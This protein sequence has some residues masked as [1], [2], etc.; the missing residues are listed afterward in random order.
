MTDKT[1]ADKIYMEP[2]TLDYVAK[3]NLDEYK[4]KIIISKKNTLP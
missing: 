3:I 1:I 4:D 2:L